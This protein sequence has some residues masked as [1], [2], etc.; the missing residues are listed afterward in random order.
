MGWADQGR[1]QG[2]PT[3]VR[4]IDVLAMRLFVDDGGLS[5]D[6]TSSS[7]RDDVVALGN[8]LEQRVRAFLARHD[9]VSRG[10]GSILKHLRTLHKNGELNDELLR[11]ARLASGGRVVDPSPAH[12]K[13]ILHMQ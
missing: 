4:R 7:Y 9:V 8:V 5:L 10:A 12:T 6:E 13:F 11:F 3:W 2:D 1:P